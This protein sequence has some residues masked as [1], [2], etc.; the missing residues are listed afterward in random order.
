MTTIDYT[1]EEA[2]EIIEGEKLRLAYMAEAKRQLA[3][4]ENAARWREISLTNEREIP[5]GASY[6]VDHLMPYN[7]YVLLTGQKKTGKTTLMMNLI[8]ALT[9]AEKFL[10]EFGVHERCRVALFDMEMDGRQHMRWLDSVGLLHE[11]KL[12]TEYLRGEARALG[13]G[14]DEREEKLVE[15]LSDLGIDVMIIDPIGPLLRA[16]GVDENSTDVGQIIDRIIAVKEAAGIPGLIIN[17]HQGK[18]S[19]LGARGSSVFEDTPDAIWSLTRDDREKRTTLTAFGRDFDTERDLEYNPDTHV[20][21]ATRAGGSYLDADNSKVITDALR[22]QPGL[23]GRALFDQIKR[24][25]YKRNL[26]DLN[27]DLREL[28]E[29]GVVTN[30]GSESRPKWVLA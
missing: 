19:K 24:V 20:L 7:G 5:P 21:S 27:D 17:Q 9:K 3:A 15:R 28:T 22:A 14:D 25:G 26:T 6:M 4:M 10:G 2:V 23:S 30:E 1:T 8:K 12:Y 16:H 11:K 18:D 13:I 29:R